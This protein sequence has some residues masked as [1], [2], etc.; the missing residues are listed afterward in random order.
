MSNSNI[1]RLNSR[2]MALYDEKQDLKQEIEL[3]ECMGREVFDLEEQLFELDHS[4]TELE[5]QLHDHEMDHLEHMK[6]AV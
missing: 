2:L 3:T 6:E 5:R 1:E 4:I